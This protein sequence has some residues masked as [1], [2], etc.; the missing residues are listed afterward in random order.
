MIIIEGINYISISVS[1][2]DNAVKFY[3]DMF[4][5]DVIEK[6]SGM[7]EALLQLG[8]VKLR[9]CEIDNFSENSRKEDFL[10]FSVDSE[11]F[12]DIL[13]EVEEKIIPISG[14]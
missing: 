1:N 2:I 4:E 13:D 6:Q 9:L 5:F 11:D 12:D 14:Y 7:S 3:K 8:E 10:C